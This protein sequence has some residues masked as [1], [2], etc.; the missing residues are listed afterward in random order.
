MQFRDQMIAASLKHSYPHL[1]A[2]VRVEFRDQ[3]IAASMKP[4]QGSGFEF[5]RLNSAIS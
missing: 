5:G 2:A 4:G 3:M 1:S